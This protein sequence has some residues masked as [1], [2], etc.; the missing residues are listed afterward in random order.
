MSDECCGPGEPVIPVV[1]DACCGSSGPT[2]PSEKLKLE[3]LTPWWRDRALLLPVASG[4][5]WVVGLLIGWAGL[6]AI[7][8]AA[9]VL[10]LLA[11]AW[12]FIPGTLRRLVQGRGRGRLG[13]SLLMTITAVGAVILGY[14]EEAAALAFL[15]SIAEALED[16]SMDRAR[17]RDCGHCSTS[18]PTLLPSPSTVRALRPSRLQSRG[19][20]SMLGARR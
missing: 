9:H 20:R 10:A 12:T 3:E 7:G 15:Y 19:L 16:K 11:G 4:A 6:D 5:L 14:I 1:E 17:S 18:S 13:I 2:D 8:L